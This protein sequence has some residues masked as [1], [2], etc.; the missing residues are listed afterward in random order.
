MLYLHGLGHF[1]PENVIDNTFLESLDIGT[2]DEWIMERVGIAERRTVLP[3][4][5][6]RATRNSDPRA[7]HEASVYTNAQT[8]VRAADLAIERAGLQASDIGMVICGGCSPQYSIPAEAC[9]VAEA[10]GLCVPAFDI[11]SACSSFVAHLDVLDGMRPEKLPTFVLI[12]SAENNTRVVDY[13][14]RNTAI[15]WG[16]GTS[17]AVVSARVPAPAV[18]RNVV[19]RSDPSG[20]RTVLIP[21]GGFFA[22]Q[23]SAVQMFAIRKTSDTTRELL[24]AMPAEQAGGSWFIGHQ[25]NLGMLR[26]SAR[27][28]GV[29]EAKH[30]HNVARFGNCGAAGAPS[31]LSQH[32]GTLPQGD[33]LALVVVGSGLSWGGAIIA[34]EG[35]HHEI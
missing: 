27:R 34:F 32:W 21:T 7:A 12:V 5:Y 13:R 20:W 18:V 2:T 30:L 9:I 4:D 10:L 28:G 15:L 24:A 33:Q 3:L 23:G 11:N 14:D 17:A 26:S 19:F 29:D 25:A 22:Q 1:H 35:K 8:T 31:V 16:D 6:I